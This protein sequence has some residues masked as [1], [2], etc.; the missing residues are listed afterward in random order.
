M[1]EYPEVTVVTNALN[2]LVATKKIIKVNVKDSKFLHNCSLE[3]F[4]NFLINKTITSVKNIGKFIIFNFDD[5][6]R[7]FSHLRMAGK[8]YFCHKKQLPEYDFPHNYLYFYFQDDTVLIYNDSRTF[9]SFE[10]YNAN[11]T[12]TIYQIK[13]I[14]LLPKD[15]D[16]DQLYDRLQRK[17]ISIKAALLD[18]SL[19][20]G[21]GNIYVDETLH[22]EKVYPMTKCNK[23]SKEKL[24]QILQ[25]AQ[26]IMDESIK[27]GGST[28][29]SYKSVNGIDGKY[30]LKLKAYG[31]AGLKC[32]S[33]HRYNIIKVKLDFKSNGRGTSYCPN[34]QKEEDE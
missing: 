13:N 11:D 5:N 7:M 17:N 24:A 28:V 12:R 19:V 27:L 1:P 9:G 22:F 4:E 14:A 33:C 3:E 29:N 21:I 15:V 26:R 34:C 23:I 32:L 31:R 16:V 10:I 25:T 6:S 18:Q 20:L 2:K 30:Q 8:Y